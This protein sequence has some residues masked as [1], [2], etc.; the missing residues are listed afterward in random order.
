M[1][2]KAGRRKSTSWIAKWKTWIM[3]GLTLLLGITFLFLFR[4][5]FDMWFSS[6]KI[7]FGGNLLGLMLLHIIVASA[8]SVLG[9][10]FIYFTSKKMR[11]WKW[12]TIICICFLLYVGVMFIN[13]TVGIP[14]LDLRLWDLNGGVVIGGSNI[15]CTDSSNR[16]LVGQNISCKF[17]VPL[18]EYNATVKFLLQNGSE[19]NHSSYNEITFISPDNVK[20]IIFEIDGIDNNTKTRKLGVSS[21]FTFLT[22]Q[23]DI[24]RQNKVVAYF[25]ALLG[26]TLFS[27]PAMMRN[28]E[29]LWE[30]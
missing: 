6:I 8:V 19:T 4:T 16:L 13:L 15:S 20:R 14:N 26:I 27:V 17:N 29:S 3:G 10:L 7:L 12:A 25:L 5:L 11:W 1:A 21:E 30:K 18:I 9:I 28:L 22:P 24:D 2:N 23:G